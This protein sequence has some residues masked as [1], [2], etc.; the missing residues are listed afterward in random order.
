MNRYF[1][2]LL[3]M[4]ATLSIN[5]QS[6]GYSDRGQD[7]Y[8]D[9]DNDRHHQQDWDN[10]YNDPNYYP[11]DYRNY[12]PPPP[13]RGCGRNVVVVSPPRSFCAPVYIAPPPPVRYCYQ[14]HRYYN[15]YG[16]RHHRGRWR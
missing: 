11:N 13:S 1:F 3:L 12:P 2:T 14:P 10:P 16:H 5:A 9:R 4:I 7:R 6:R 15:R 8:D